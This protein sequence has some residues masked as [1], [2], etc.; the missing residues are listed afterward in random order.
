ML[1]V[2]DVAPVDMTY[3]AAVDTIRAMGEV[4]VFDVLLYLSH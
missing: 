1:I 4:R 3:R 2:Y